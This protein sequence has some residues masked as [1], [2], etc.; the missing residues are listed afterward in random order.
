LKSAPPWT[1]GS[2]PRVRRFFRLFLKILLDFFQ[3][4]FRSNWLTINIFFFGFYV[5]LL[6]GADD[7]KLRNYGHE[8]EV[9]RLLFRRRG[10]RKNA[11]DATGACALNL[12]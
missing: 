8:D 1:R 10:S 9:K 5:A 2:T 6:M 12:N 7:L 11:Q 4:F 3:V